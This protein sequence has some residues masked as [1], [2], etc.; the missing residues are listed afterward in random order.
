MNAGPEKSSVIFVLWSHHWLHIVTLHLIHAV[1]SQA[2]LLPLNSPLFVFFIFFKFI[3]LTLGNNSVVKDVTID[4]VNTSSS[5][6]FCDALVFSICIMCQ[7]R[8]NDIEGNQE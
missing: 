8:C 2:L 5:N 6:I 1:H 7:K 4:V 3:I